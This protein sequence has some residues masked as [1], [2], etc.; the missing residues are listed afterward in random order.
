MEAGAG[1]KLLPTFLS[2]LASTTSSAGVEILTL[3]TAFA[4]ISHSEEVSPDPI[5][6]LEWVGEPN[7]VDV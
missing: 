4:R 6:A 5:L 7:Y 2:F 3:K 1:E